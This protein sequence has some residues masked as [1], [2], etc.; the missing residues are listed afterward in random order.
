MNKWTKAAAVVF[1]AAGAGGTAYL[2]WNFRMPLKEYT[3]YALYMAMLDEKICRNELEGNQI[4]G[5]TIRFPPQAETLQD[6]Y[7]LFLRRN[8]RKSRR[9]I[10]GEIAGMERR[11]QTS[12]QY[13]GK[14]KENLVVVTGREGQRQ[15]NG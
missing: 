1:L 11:L 5:K 6:R 13:L 7:H 10:Q 9:M 14:P 15:K 12:I 2:K 4:D 8:R 3:Q